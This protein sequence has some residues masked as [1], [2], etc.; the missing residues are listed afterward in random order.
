MGLITTERADNLP[1]WNMVSPKGQNK[2]LFFP[3]DFY[4]IKVFLQLYSGFQIAF[5]SSSQKTV[6]I[7]F[8]VYYSYLILQCIAI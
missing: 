3:P 6:T 5:H 2:K 7:L 8:Y 4:W 1:F